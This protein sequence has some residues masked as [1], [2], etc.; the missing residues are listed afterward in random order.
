MTGQFNHGLPL[1]GDCWPGSLIK[2][3]LWTVME[4]VFSFVFKKID[5]I[6]A[7]IMTGI[8]LKEIFCIQKELA[9]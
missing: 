5:Y 2:I 8:S 7:C 3:F 6:C 4:I 1:N 9:P